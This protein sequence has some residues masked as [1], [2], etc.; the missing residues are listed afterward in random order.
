M[1]AC[2][3]ARYLG[4]VNKLLLLKYDCYNLVVTF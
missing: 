2:V 1:A 3:V 4:L